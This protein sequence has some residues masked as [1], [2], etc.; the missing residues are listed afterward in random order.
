MSTQYVGSSAIRIL[1]PL[2][3]EEQIDVEREIRSFDVAHDR[4]RSA[5][6]RKTLAPHCVSEYFKPKKAAERSR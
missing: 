3:R 6:R 1:Q 4:V 5:L 2:H